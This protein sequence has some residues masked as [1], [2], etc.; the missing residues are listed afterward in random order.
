MSPVIG[1]QFRLILSSLVTGMWLMASYDFLRT[2]RVI[3]I[4]KSFVINLEDLIYWIYAGILV[5]RFLYRENDGNLRSFMI[6][7]V[8]AGMVVFNKYISRNWLKLLKKTVK[9][10]KMKITLSRKR[11][12]DGPDDR[13]I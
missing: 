10:I 13:M 4:H 11:S 1:N 3:F 2:L 7:G 5:F 8:F 9:Y 12:E 6:A